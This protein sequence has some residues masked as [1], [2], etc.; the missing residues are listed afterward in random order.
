[1]I[2]N[3]LRNA[4]LSVT[5]AIF[6]SSLYS[7]LA[8]SSEKSCK[9]V[10]AFQKFDPI[11]WIQFAGSIWVNVLKTIPISQNATIVEVAPGRAS[12]IG[13]ALRELN[14]R[15]TIYIVEPHLETMNE[16]VANYQKLLPQAK[17]VGIPRILKEAIPILPKRPDAL[18]SNHPL[19]DMIAAASLTKLEANEYAGEVNRYRNA[20]MSEIEAVWSRIA[21]SRDLER[22]LVEEV[23]SEWQNAIQILDP[24]YTIV[25]Q[26]TSPRHTS[27]PLLAA[28]RLGNY[29]LQELKRRFPSNQ[30]A[31]RNELLEVGHDPDR[32]MI[33]GSNKD[34]NQEINA[35]PDALKALGSSMM[36]TETLRKISTDA[37][38]VTYINRQLLAELG[39]SEL[40]KDESDLVTRIKNAFG[41][42]LDDSSETQTKMAWADRQRDPMNI[43]LNGN[44]GSGRAVYYGKSFN[45]KGVGQT[46][47]VGK[48]ADADHRN[49]RISFSSAAWEALGGNTINSEITLGSSPI[50]T[51]IKLKKKMARPWDP[52]GDPV[53]LALVVRIDNGSLIRPTHALHESAQRELLDPVRFAERVGRAEGEKF[54]QRI[55]HGAW[56]AGNTSVNGHII[57]MDTVSSVETRNPQYSFVDRFESTHF[58]LEWQGFRELLKHFKHSDLKSLQDTLFRSR[59][60]AIALGFGNLLGYNLD[61]V[62]LR[63]RPEYQELEVLSQEFEYLSTRVNSLGTSPYTADGSGTANAYFDFS[64]MLRVLPSVRGLHMSEQSRV[65]VLFDY[66]KRTSANVDSTQDKEGTAKPHS[67]VQQHFSGDAGSFDARAKVF[68]QRLLAMLDGKT[69]PELAISP[70]DSFTRATIANETR[71][72]LMD[73][74]GQKIVFSWAEQV[75]AGHLGIDDFQFYMDEAIRGN[76]RFS[77]AIEQNKMDLAVREVYDSELRIFEGGSI[78]R[79]LN[80]KG[81]SRFSLR[82]LNSSEFNKVR[83]ASIEIDGTIFKIRAT[84]NAKYFEIQ[85]PWIP[86]KGPIT[87]QKLAIKDQSGNTILLRPFLNDWKYDSISYYLK[88]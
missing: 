67:Y 3:K 78:C 80:D 54:V 45:V 57:D 15:G 61:Y 82:F 52:T 65:D 18:I 72:Y 56:S 33:V 21:S 75:E 68:I 5:V 79:Q 34:F 62:P 23:A 69:S 55:V 26:Y 9:S 6:L 64:R 87:T 39:Y 58:G 16:I 85:T 24:S 44:E 25:S 11:D 42:E 63:S 40:L 76:S 32:W 66:L 4:I 38:D 88:H 81:Q 53:N 43:A 8:F 37:M 28:D 10:F 7:P 74:Y 14:F 86:W 22:R 47:L 19:D 60:D 17:V 84:E 73:S 29:C 12:K 83:P 46:K 71:V 41:W 13:T 51:V 36:V 50:L 48:H 77:K 49:G 30:F 59:K 2:V 35:T 20:E 27:G 31:R 70:R 1:M